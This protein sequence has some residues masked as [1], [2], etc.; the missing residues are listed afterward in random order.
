MKNKI[1]AW[2]GL[3]LL[4][5]LGWSWLWLGYHSSHQV[6]PSF[7]P[8][9]NSQALRKSAPQTKVFQIVPGSEI[10]DSIR[11]IMG[12]NGEDYTKRSKALQALGN[13]LSRSEIEA[14]YA[15]LL[16]SGQLECSLQNEVINAL[17]EQTTPPTD[18]LDVLSYLHRDPQQNQM[19]RDY[20]LQHLVAEYEKSPTNAIVNQIP[21]LLWD[22]LRVTNSSTVGTALLGLHRLC[23]VDP[24]IDSNKVS[25]VALQLTLDAA[26]GELARITAL[27]VCAQRRLHDVLPTVTNMA[28]HAVSLPLRISAIAA[29]GYLGEERERMLL[30]MLSAEGN[31]FLQPAIKSALNRLNRRLGTS[32]STFRLFY[33]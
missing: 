10:P 33:E 8:K 15:L 31:D 20:A 29:L 26:T 3:A 22:A 14:L 18:L 13:N 12:L 17:R 19:S 23:G 27:Q 24:T 2:I 7:R 25:Q 1:I 9:I 5:V 32:Q 21:E 16:S 30:E 11:P 28:Q 4:V 6:Q